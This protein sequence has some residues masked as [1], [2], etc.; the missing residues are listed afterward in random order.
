MAEFE[1]QVAESQPRAAPAAAT[2]FV[3]AASS[4][5]VHAPP[6]HWTQLAS[7]FTLRI[8]LPPTPPAFLFPPLQP[9]ESTSAGYTLLP[10]DATGTAPTQPDPT[11]PIPIVLGDA[12]QTL[13]PTQIIHF[14]YE[15]RWHKVLL[16]A[17]TDGLLRFSCPPYWLVHAHTAWTPAANQIVHTQVLAALERAEEEEKAAKAAARTAK[18]K[19]DT[20]LPGKRKRDR[21]AAEAAVV[22]AAGSSKVEEAKEFLQA[23]KEADDK[24]TSESGTVAAVNGDAPEGQPP[25]K[26]TK[27]TVEE[28]S[29]EPAV[30][31]SKKRAKA[32][33]EAEEDSKSEYKLGMPKAEDGGKIKKGKRSAKLDVRQPMAESSGAAHDPV[34]GPINSSTMSEKTQEEAQ[35]PELELRK[36]LRSKKDTPLDIEPEK[37]ISKK[38]RKSNT[39]KN[40]EDTKLKKS[41]SSKIAE[42]AD[43]DS[44]KKSKKSVSTIVEVVIP[45]KTKKVAKVRALSDDEDMS[46]K[47]SKSKKGSTEIKEE[48]MPKKKSRESGTEKDTVLPRKS[49]RNKPETDIEDSVVKK[50]K[51][52]SDQDVVS[53]KSK[54]TKSNQIDSSEANLKQDKKSNKLRKGADNKV[55][56]NSKRKK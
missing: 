17:H 46:S 6:I 19:L 26:R 13:T 40:E 36:S 21:L 43:E 31:K 8:P 10:A 18:G 54:T 48:S 55:D 47:P 7:Q 44:T 33:F 1:K 25:A 28:S 15:K 42:N 24:V 11:I 34:D 27:T 2:P 35:E 5:I 29:D 56:K 45:F 49:K 37:P 41:K 39:D 20:S 12:T 50:P 16:K 4:E 9:A 3:P 22:T 52:D 14:F 30:K 38:A 23:V 51:T 32:S 53:K